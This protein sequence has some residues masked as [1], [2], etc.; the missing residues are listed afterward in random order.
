MQRA[1]VHLVGAGPG[2]PELLTLKAAKLLARA[3]MIVHDRLVSREILDLAPSAAE[4]VDVGKSL[5]LHRVTQPG[6]N[7]LLVELAMPGRLLIRLKGGDPLMFGRGGEEISHLLAHGIDVEIIPG[8]TSASGCAAVAGI[9]L[10]Q[11]GLATGVRFITAHMQS[12]DDSAVDWRGLAD[13][14]TTLVVFM[15]LGKIECLARR[16]MAEGLEPA[17]PVAA[18][19]NGTHAEER[20]IRADLRTIAQCA[21]ERELEA[22]VLFII[23]KV[24]A[25]LDDWRPGRLPVPEISP[26]PDHANW[27]RYGILPDHPVAQRRR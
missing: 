10:T 3:D 15:G 9:P 13:P 7:R 4:L 16:L 21:A 1:K 24:V 19:E 27:P 25:S 5:G 18:I 23:G 6:I 22:P 26:S 2:D 17:T 11:R 8:V 20:V 14:S 12:D